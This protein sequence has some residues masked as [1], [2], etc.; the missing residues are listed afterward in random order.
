VVL[1]AAGAI[2]SNL[3]VLRAGERGLRTSDISARTSLGAVQ[4]AAPVVA[5]GFVADP[6]AAPQVAAGPY[7]AAVHDLGSP[8][9]SL[10]ELERASEGQREEAD[11]VLVKAERVT[12]RPGRGA[13]IGSCS[14]LP[15]GA[16]QTEV[17]VRPGATATVLPEPRT[18]VAV[19]VRRFGAAAPTP[20]AA[21]VTGPATIS[22][23]ADAAPQVPW[24]LR[25]AG[26]SAAQV[27]VR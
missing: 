2:V 20:L 5:P 21:A 1:L 18:H 6:S 24:R 14:R 17:T 4:L 12:V 25:V 22:F 23:P 19:S 16:S 10:S 9:L 7:L 11:G 26:S 15:V 13:V 27:C 8:A 3:H